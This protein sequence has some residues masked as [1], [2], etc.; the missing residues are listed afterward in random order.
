MSTFQIVLLSAGLSLA[1]GLGPYLFVVPSLLV[2]AVRGWRRGPV[3][4]VAL[5]RQIAAGFEAGIRTTPEG[6]D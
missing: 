5:G 6:R 4:H 3:D 1:I 2:D